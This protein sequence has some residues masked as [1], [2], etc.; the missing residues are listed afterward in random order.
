[1]SAVRAII[2]GGKAHGEV[3][4]IEAGRWGVKA[5]EH[6]E[7]GVFTTRWLDLRMWQAGRW[8][9]PILTEV[10]DTGNVEL[11][12]DALLTA[13]SQANGLGQRI[14]SEAP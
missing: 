9:F 8:V 7:L 14:E 10:H 11:I 3:Y 13:L 12:S 6:K 4:E 2:V 1:M 5:V